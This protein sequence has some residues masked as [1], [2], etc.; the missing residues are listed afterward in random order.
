MHGIVH[1]T[2][3]RYVTDRAGADGWDA[4]LDRA[5][6]EPT[7]YLPVSHYPDEDVTAI[8]ETVAAMSGTD[9]TAVE[10]D[11]GRTLAPELVGTFRA[12]LGSDPDPFDVLERLDEIYDDLRAADEQL[13]P[14]PVECE[15][16][17]DALRVTYRSPRDHPG[18]A[19]GILEG[20]FETFE[21]DA[22]VSPVSSLERGAESYVFEVAVE[23]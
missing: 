16:S 21:V 19:Y 20:L 3:K 18:I 23:S 1:Q 22:T 14:P 9:L 6:V 8:L 10:R 2:L 7:L 15:R 17:G 11:F 5:G 13:E 12:H 4:V